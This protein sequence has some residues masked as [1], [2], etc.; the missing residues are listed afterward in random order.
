VFSLI[1][2]EVG[3]QQVAGISRLNSGNSGDHIKLVLLILDDPSALLSC[4]VR[5]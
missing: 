1:G 5:P 3:G 4:L 2:Q